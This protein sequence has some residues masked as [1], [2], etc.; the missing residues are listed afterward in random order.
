MDWT[1]DRDGEY[2]ATY[3]PTDQGLHQIEVTVRDSGEFFAADTSFLQVTDLAREFYD[4]EMQ[5]AALRRIADETGG[6]FYTP[7][8][9]SSLPEDISYTESGTTVIEE[10]DLWDMP[11]LFVLVVG[12]VSLEWGFRRV[13]GLV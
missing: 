10:N 12:L 8:T 5:Q 1:V 7:S 4:A 6:Q 11:I 9:L 3:T 2:R 13:R